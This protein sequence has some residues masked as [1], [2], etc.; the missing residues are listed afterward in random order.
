MRLHIGRNQINVLLCPP[1]LIGWCPSLAVLFL[2]VVM[3]THLHHIWPTV[4]TQLH[5][6]LLGPVN[7]GA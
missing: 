1:F 2:A 4:F 5:R 7:F 6:Y 3:A